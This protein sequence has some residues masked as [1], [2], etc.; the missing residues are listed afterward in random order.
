MLSYKFHIYPSKTVQAKL[1]EQLELC[2]WLYNILYILP[3]RIIY[4]VLWIYRGCSKS[5]FEAYSLEMIK[6][7]T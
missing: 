2:R 7:Q 6:W 5:G 4:E 1:Q 3:I